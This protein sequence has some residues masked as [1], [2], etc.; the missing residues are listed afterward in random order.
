MLET[1]TLSEKRKM[2]LILLLQGPKTI[3][4]IK[5]CLNCRSSPAM[6]Q[7][8]ILLKKKLIE[9]SD[10][11]YCLS[12]LGEFLVPE[13]ENVVRLFETLST[14]ENYWTEMDIESLP[15]HMLERIGDIG[16]AELEI[17]QRAYIFECCEKMVQ[18]ME[19]C[20]TLIEISSIFKNPYIR[21]YVWIAEKR[22]PVSLVFTKDVAERLETEYPQIFYRFLRMDNVRF[23]I[24]DNIE[25]ASCTITD[26]FLALSLFT[27]SGYYCNHNLI[28]YEKS[29]L[30]WGTDLFLYYRSIAQV[31]T[32]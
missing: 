24:T 6:V 1:L 25:F 26:N 31:R 29:A 17:P 5:E 3:E 22:I 9:E 12:S 15:N 18:Y 19:R 10:N 23:F 20:N 16:K 32:P 30:E 8:R 14:P 28:S 27:K 7:I 13:M 21:E 2:I 4:E 11:K